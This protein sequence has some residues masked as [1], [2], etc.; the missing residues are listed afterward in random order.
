MDDEQLFPGRSISSD[1]ADY[2]RAA[3]A[4]QSRQDSAALRDIGQLPPVVNQARRDRGGDD[5]RCFCEEYF[6]QRFYLGFCDDHLRV[7]DKVETVTRKGGLSAIALP[8]GYGKSTITECAVIW[9]I[10]Y[11]YHQFVALIAATH[12]AAEERLNGVKTALET[13]DL[14]LA[15][16][17]EVCYPLRRLEGIT[18]RS[19]GQT[20]CGAPTNITWGKK[21]IVLPT[22]AGSR[23]SG[24]IVK[25]AALLGA[26][27][28][29]SV[30][31]AD[32]LVARPSLAVIDDPQTRESASSFDQTNK[33]E[34]IISGD[35]LYLAGP[36]KKISA[37]MP[38]TVIE[39]DDLADRVLCRERT[40]EWNG[41]RTQMLYSFPK[42]RDLWDKYYVLRC[43]SL[44]QDGDGS[45][46]TEFYRENRVAMD[47]G[48]VVA[49]SSKFNADE[50]SGVQ[51]AMNLFL[52]DQVS[53][54]C[55]AQNSPVSQQADGTLLSADAIARKVNGYKRGEI[56][57]DVSHVTLGIDVQKELLYWTLVGWGDGFTGY[58]LDY[59]AW[60][61]QGATYFTLDSAR[62]TLSLA[63]E[64]LG[65][66]ARL[67]RG[68]QEL[69]DDLFGR[70]LCRDDGAELKIDLGL[71]DAGWGESTDVVYSFCRQ[72]KRPLFPA[73]GRSIGVKN[74]P[75][76]QYRKEAGA[77]IGHHW[78]M[79]PLKGKRAVRYVLSDVNFWKSF[80]HQRFLT[81]L[82]G[83]G[84]L[85]LFN[86]DAKRHQMFAEHMRAEFKVPVSGPYGQCDEWSLRPGRPDNHFFDCLVA[87]AVA[88]SIVGVKLD[89][90]GGKIASTGA[91]FARGGSS[92]TKS[93]AATPRPGRRTRQRVSYM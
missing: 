59:G 44:R 65:L 56:P 18:Q 13:N 92:T 83:S 25:A 82:G 30:T 78:Y 55:E 91:A 85:S 35:V 21:Q 73:H 22:I 39:K 37:I 27:R 38:C 32:G 72:S 11:G 87:A 15:D 53:F 1:R 29:M 50:I 8:R 75:F 69:T 67:M 3:A 84:A 2:R 36:G 14:L 61:K 31:R 80:V 89:E 23:A 28:G 45:E 81:S 57:I 86:D 58:V 12:P 64:G 26:V 47:E 54:A 9:A 34:K 6:Q 43:E 52:R 5:F 68:L 71:A 48:A 79:P 49:W 33:R 88:A 62:K 24:A 42:N 7:I 70:T 16:F 20:F 46:A 4:F 41:I 76:S 51:H 60:P 40:P 74:K 77:R 19:K 90:S 63:Y 66:E 93:S 10:L 17:P